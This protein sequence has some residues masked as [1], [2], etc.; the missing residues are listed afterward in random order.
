MQIYI[1]ELKYYVTSESGK[2][3]QQNKLDN[4]RAPDP[5]LISFSP[6]STYHKCR[7]VFLGNIKVNQEVE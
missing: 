5:N 3:V 7:I 4:Y 2:N 1:C 6:E